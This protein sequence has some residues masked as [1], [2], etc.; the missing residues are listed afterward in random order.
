MNLSSGSPAR[1]RYLSDEQIACIVHQ[2]TT[3]LQLV[4]G[5]R[6]SRAWPQLAAAGKRQ[7]VEQVRAIRRHEE[8]PRDR[9]ADELLKDDLARLM[10]CWLA[11]VQL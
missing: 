9:P 3:G 4:L 2:A 7:V 11:T 8:T 6:T 1:L 10:A 5:E